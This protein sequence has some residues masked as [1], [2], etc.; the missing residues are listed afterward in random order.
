MNVVEA[1]PAGIGG[2]GDMD[3]AAGQTPDQEAVDCP[4]TQL[5]GGGAV[6]RALDPV[7]DPGKFGG[8]EIG[9]EKKA[10][11]FRHHGFLAGILHHRADV[12]GA[13]VLPDDGVVDRL[14]GGAVPDDGGLALVGDADGGRHAAARPRLG[15]HGCRHIDGGLPDVLRIMLDPAIRREMLRELGRLLRQDGAGLVKEDGA[16]AGG[17]LVDGDDGAKVGHGTSVPVLSLVWLAFLAWRGGG[18]SASDIVPIPDAF[19]DRTDAR[20]ARCWRSGSRG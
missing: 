12:G 4:E 13:P 7:K 3:P 6:A 16:R 17:A 9:V 18:V 15:D 8:G 19:P 11:L 14:A 1:G 10:G 2:V 20:R 5:A